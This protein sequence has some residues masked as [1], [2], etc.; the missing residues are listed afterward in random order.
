MAQQTRRTTAR[1]RNREARFSWRLLLIG[2]ALGLA[3]MWAVQH[4][5]NGGRL[6]GLRK[7]FAHHPTANAPAQPPA[8][9][10]TAL[11]KPTF[12]FY[13]ILPEVGSG[14]PEAARRSSARSA[15]PESPGKGVRYILQAAAYTNSHDADHLRARLALS[16]IESYTEK[17]SVEGRGSYYR[18]R[19]GPFASM[20]AM[21]SVDHRLA[22]LGI[23]AIPLKVKAAPRT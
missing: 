5:L 4:M 13:T 12:D 17:V 21:A 9:A 18:V 11:P 23:R 15:N 6:T 2:F 16:G 7:F 3:V 8:A 19:L 1:H 20:A 22:R 10:A 14:M